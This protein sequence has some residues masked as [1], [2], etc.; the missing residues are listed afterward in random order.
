MRV[1]MVVGRLRVMMDDDGRLWIRVMGEV[2][3]EGSVD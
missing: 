3:V 1:V 2:M